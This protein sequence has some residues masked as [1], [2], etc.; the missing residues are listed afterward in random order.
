MKLK[1]LV[2]LRRAGIL[3]IQVQRNYDY[4]LKIIL[5]NLGLVQEPESLL[6]ITSAQ[7][8]AT[9]ETILWKDLAYNSE[10]M[11]RATAREH[12][13]Y[14]VNE[15]TDDNTSTY[16]NGDWPEYH[17][18]SS[19]GWNPMTSATFD[20]GVIVIHKDYVACLWVEDED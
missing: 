1:E 6:K 16:S 20:A 15:F 18:R 3:R 4:D 17:Q 8:I 11:P 14:F 13:E 7:A 19:S 9:V 10:L 2:T 5:K 12:A